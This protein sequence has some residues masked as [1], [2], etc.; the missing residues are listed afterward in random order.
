[1]F[2]P[3]ATHPFACPL[4]DARTTGNAMRLGGLVLLGL[5]AA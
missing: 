1:M 5:P 4:R 3:I 2:A